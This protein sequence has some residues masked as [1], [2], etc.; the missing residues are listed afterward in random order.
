MSLCLVWRLWTERIV[1]SIWPAITSAVYIFWNIIC[2][3]LFL[4]WL[5][6]LMLIGRH[7]R[8]LSTHLRLTSK[9]TMP[10]YGMYMCVYNT[11]YIP[12][13]AYHSVAVKLAQVTWK[14]RFTIHTSSSFASAPTT[15]QTVARTSCFAVNSWARSPIRIFFYCISFFFH[16]SWLLSF[17]LWIVIISEN[18]VECGF[19]FSFFFLC[20][21]RWSEIA[22]VE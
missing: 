13:T 10:L 18:Y 7:A 14:L 5:I 16:L 22:C 19:H 1:Q 17:R 20:C 9:R 21:T 2:L 4:F 6:I 12:H 11:Y 15:S 3:F 8:W